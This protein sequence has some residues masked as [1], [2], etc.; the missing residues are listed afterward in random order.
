MIGQKI[1][2]AIVKSLA[3]VQGDIPYST[4]RSGSAPTA[5]ES[6]VL[7]LFYNEV[8][9]EPYDPITVFICVVDECFCFLEQKLV[10]RCSFSRRDTLG[11]TAKTV[12]HDSVELVAV[13]RHD[14]DDLIKHH[15]KSG[16]VFML[17]HDSDARVVVGWNKNGWIDRF[18]N[19]I[20]FG[21]EA[22]QPVCR[23]KMIEH[24]S[25]DALYDPQSLFTE[26]SKTLVTLSLVV[27][28]G[29]FGYFLAN[30]C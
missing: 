26:S 13:V 14:C 21:L 2:S 22:V 15:I 17:I 20:P 3:S 1:R 24:F 7:S 18:D 19:Q 25:V 9:R 27:L 8:V 10:S 23:K 30:G 28:V 16:P 11:E 4:R 6:F 5:P 12:K 29:L